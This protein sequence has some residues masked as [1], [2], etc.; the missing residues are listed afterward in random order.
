MSSKRDWRCLLPSV[1][2]V[3][4]LNAKV[5]IL[6]GGP[7]VG[8]TTAVKSLLAILKK[9][10]GCSLR[11]ALCAP[12]GRAAKRLSETTGWPDKTIHRL[13]EFDPKAFRFKHD[14][15]NPLPADLLIV[16]EASM[17]DIVLMNNLLKALPSQAA[18]LLIG[19]VDQLP[20]VG[21]GRVLADLIE[22]GKTPTARLTEIFRQAACSRIIVNAH[23]VNQ[24]QMP[25]PTPEDSEL[26]D[27]YFVEADSPEAIHD[28]I[29]YLV[30]ERIPKRFGL[31][32]VRDIQVLT[33]M[34]RGGVGRRR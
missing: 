2:L 4:A 34:H 9:L 25:L 10:Q 33:P 14:Q 20:S 16:D 1:P 29:L 22:S 18:L 12:T 6:T 28:K 8:K 17:L 3:E 23:R 21:P 19:D 32:P 11:I 30:T 27:F 13:L 5:F 26:S 31:H 7:G 24:G 15:A